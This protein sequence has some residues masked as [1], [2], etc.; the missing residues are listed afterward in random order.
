LLLSDTNFSETLWRSEFL[1][2]NS[3]ASFF[4]EPVQ[5]KAKVVSDSNLNLFF[6]ETNR[7]YSRSIRFGLG[8][9]L[10]LG[11]TEQ[12]TS[13][14]HAMGIQSIAFMP[15][16]AHEFRPW[17]SL[18]YFPHAKSHL[19]WEFAFGAVEIPMH[20]FVWINRKNSLQSSFEW[21]VAVKFPL[22]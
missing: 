18:G 20:F 17:I 12:P 9:N 3:G 11:F 15:A 4:V 7:N 5:K 16:F 19:R 22:L 21:G 1:S 10:K 2:L 13:T 6:P 14:L 8:A